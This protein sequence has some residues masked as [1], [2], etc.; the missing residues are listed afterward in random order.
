MNARSI[1]QR[2]KPHPAVTAVHGGAMVRSRISPLYRSNLA[3]TSQP[4]SS[5]VRRRGVAAHQAE[6]LLRDRLALPVF[7]LPQRPVHAVLYSIW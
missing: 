3:F 5:K 2:S 4:Q 6:V 7:I 1:A